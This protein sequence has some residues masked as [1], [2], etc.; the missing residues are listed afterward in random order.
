MKKLA[1]L[2]FLLSTSVLAQ[3]A[4]LMVGTSHADL[5]ST[6]NKTGV[7]LSELSHAYDVF[8]EHGFKVEFASIDGD[9]FPL[10]PGSLEDMD[11][12]AKKFLLSNN[13]RQ[14][15]SDASVMP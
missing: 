6:G 9:G 13:K 14:L 11:E 7:W 5:G 10:D 1:F 4:V 12:S 3:P 15:I 8:L 2:L